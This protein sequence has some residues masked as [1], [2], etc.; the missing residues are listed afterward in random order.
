MGTIMSEPEKF[1]MVT[2]WRKGLVQV[3]QILATFEQID[4][5]AEE[6]MSRIDG[7]EA[8]IFTVPGWED[9]KTVIGRVR[10]AMQQQGIQ[11]HDVEPVQ[12]DVSQQRI[13]LKRKFMDDAQNPKN[14]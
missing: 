8:M 1:T 13:N 6:C 12:Y 9:V 2:W 5:H 10:E 4:A 11:W 14:N 3:Q 7:D